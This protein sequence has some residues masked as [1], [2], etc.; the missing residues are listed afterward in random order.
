M[1]KI[2][3]KVNEVKIFKEPVEYYSTDVG[4]GSSSIRGVIVKRK[5]THFKRK[6]ERDRYG[7]RDLYYMSN[8]K[9]IETIVK[10]RD[11]FTDYNEALKAISKYAKEKMNKK[12]SSLKRQISEMEE[13]LSQKDSFDIVKCTEIVSSDNRESVLIK[14]KC[15]ENKNA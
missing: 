13:I 10:T 9:Y 11:F 15:G 5:A 3:L 1:N 12:I 8:G 4:T 6:K 7:S 14:F 2:N